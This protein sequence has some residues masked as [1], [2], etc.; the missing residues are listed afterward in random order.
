MRRILI[1]LAAAAAVIAVLWL[2]SPVYAQAQ[3]VP[4]ETAA[5]KQL[6]MY[7]RVSAKGKIEQTVE[8]KI[9]AQSSMKILKV[10]VS[11]GDTAE[12]GQ[13]LFQAE[14]AEASA[15]PGSE[16]ISSAARLLGLSE[17]DIRAAMAQ[18][19]DL[20][21]L[22]EAAETEEDS[23][24]FDGDIRSPINGVVTALSVSEGDVV[25]A[26][27]L[28]AC[29]SDLSS[30]QVRAQIPEN[31]VWR[32]K[33]GMPV[34]IEGDAFGDRLF[35]GVVAKLMPVAEQASSI[36]G[37]TS[38][39]VEALVRILSRNTGLRPGYTANLWIYTSKRS[40]ALAIPYE[41]ITQDENNREAVF[42]Y[43]EGRVYKRYIQTGF[44]LDELVEVT[45]GLSPG[46]TVVRNPPE[47]LANG[48]SVRIQDSEGETE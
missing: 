44:E 20:A 25:P 29:V 34:N 1:S 47:G 26:G 31:S 14:K 5:V 18:Y 36:T 16:K 37:A 28:C 13:L 22:G 32:V 46:E 3:P 2:K 11:E 17:D 39:Y 19:P 48:Q 21:A 24:A 23:G 10:F 12:A 35:T 6:D 27:A 43:S 15:I 30:L 9:Y 41:A 38:S 40:G 45:L 4:V 42:V 7:N 8:K 33:A